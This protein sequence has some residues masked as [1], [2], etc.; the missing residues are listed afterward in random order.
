MRRRGGP[1]GSGSVASAAGLAA[2]GALSPPSPFACSPF[3]PLA[4][5]AFGAA[6]PLSAL[7]AFFAAAFLS[8][9]SSAIDLDSRTLGDAHLAA[10][11]AD[12]EAD[13]GRLA[14]LGIGDGDVGQVQWRFLGNDAA[15]LL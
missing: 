5:L 10:V 13:P 15:C 14:V 6:S 3:S 2:F 8:V 12:L 7:P 11:I 9:S 4:C 1:L